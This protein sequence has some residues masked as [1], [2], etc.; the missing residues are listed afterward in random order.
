MLTRRQFIKTAVAVMP[1]TAAGCQLVAAGK[2]AKRPNIVFVFADQMRAHAMG[3]MGNKQVITPNLDRLAREGL[4]VTNAIS[5]QP[6]CSPYR[7]QLLTGRYGHST[8]VIHNDI[9]L[10]DSE[11]V[12]SELMKKHGYTTGY[13]GKWHLSGNRDNPVD[14][15]SRRGWDFWAVRNCSHQHL[16]P[17]YW[18]NDSKEPVRVPGWEPD[19]QTDLAVEFIRKKKR[20]PFCL[21]LSFGPPHN[22][23]KA[24][25]KYVEMYKDK[26]LTDRPN[27]P[28]ADTKRLRQYYAMTTSLD[29][30]MG[31]INDALNEAGI[32]EDTIVVFSSD[33]GDMLG[34]Q[35]HRLKQR[36]WEESINIPFI[37]RYPRKV[38]KGQRRDWIVSSVDVMPT[39][40]GLCDI[41]VPSQ[42][43]GFDYSA[44]F[45]GK[46]KKQRDAAFLFNVHRGG[47]P[48]T[49]W[50]G[51]RT[52]E[53][54]YACHFSGDWVM[55]DLKNDPYQLKNLIDDPKFSAKKKELK[56]Q[57]ESMRKALGESLTLKGKMP[58]PI[59]LPV[60]STKN[61]Y[62]PDPTL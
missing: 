22:P 49:D 58:T 60:Y 4:L 18:L 20:V 33:H 27:V 13:I 6:V 54:T 53:W 37:V 40:L 38:K 47:G 12:I 39:L 3:C 26:K 43:Q 16:K 32:S 15:R 56:E 29:I 36:P 59:R 35:G 61:E 19:V 46:S 44:T 2:S 42:V 7:A 1:V 48:G 55:Y 21:F 11:V 34:S 17:E 31:R 24:P 10:P 41:P 8:G 52:K 14:A 30:C 23:Y 45:I 51:I 62:L 25:E 9:R 5:C 28:D 57:L 50:R